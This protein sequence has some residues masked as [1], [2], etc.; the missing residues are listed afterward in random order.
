M[1]SFIDDHGRCYSREADHWVVYVC[2]GCGVA[3]G[4]CVAV[5]VVAAVVADVVVAAL[6]SVFS[7][8][9]ST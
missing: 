7:V 4:A 3:G 5:G 1:K 9:I 8:D 6:S 2:A